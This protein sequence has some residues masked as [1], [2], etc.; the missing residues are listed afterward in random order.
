MVEKKPKFEAWIADCSVHSLAS[1]LAKRLYELRT[2]GPAPRVIN[3]QK[4][5]ALVVLG[6]LDGEQPFEYVLGEI[7]PSSVGTT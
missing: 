3:I 7:L 6:V 4:K 2:C 1:C 5:P